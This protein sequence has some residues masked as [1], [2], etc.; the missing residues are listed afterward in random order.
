MRTSEA[1]QKLLAEQ[2]ATWGK[3]LEK[4][5][6]ELAKKMEKLN[7]LQNEHNQFQTE[8]NSLRVEKKALEK[9]LASGDSM[10]EELERAKGELIAEKEARD[11]TIAELEKAKGSL[12]TTW[13]IP[14][15]RASRRLWIKLLV[16]TLQLTSPSAALSTI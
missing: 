3:S 8:L 12:L 16:K 13:L 4:T 10:I 5:E 7:L 15:S 6:G 9:Q 14:L 1:E 2:C 11:S